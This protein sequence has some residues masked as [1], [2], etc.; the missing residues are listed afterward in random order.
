MRKN[1]AIIF[2][3][4]MFYNSNCYDDNC[5]TLDISSSD[6]CL[7]CKNGLY[8]TYD[9][10]YCEEC[11]LQQGK[12]LYSNYKDSSDE[13]MQNCYT[14]VDNCEEYARYDDFCELC[15]DGFKRDE[16]GQCVQCPANEVGMYNVCFKKIDHCQIYYLFIEGEK[17]VFCEEN[18]EFN[19][20]QGQCIKCPEGEVSEEGD[21]CMKECPLGTFFSYGECIDEIPNCD[22]YA[23]SESGKCS[24]CYDDY[25]LKEDGTCSSCPEG[26]TGTGLKCYDIM[27]FCAHQTD[28]ICQSCSNDEEVLNEER[29]QCIKKE[30]I[31]NCNVQIN[32]KCSI[33][34]EGYKSSKDQKSCE[35][36]EPGKDE[37]IPT[38]LNIENCASYNTIINKYKKPMVDCVSC[39]SNEYYLTTSLHQCNDCEKG[40]YKLNGQCIDEIK[41][42]VQYKSETI[43]EKCRYGYQ[44]KNG[45]CSPCVTPFEG[46]DG[47]ICHLT[48]FRCNEANIDDYG[49]C[50]ECD[51]GYILNSKKLCVKEG[52]EHEND[53]KNNSFGLN[54]NFIFLI[55]Y[56]LLI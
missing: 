35:I 14:K 48:H 30:K 45:R 43:C 2:I 39:I 24:K 40:K 12:I 50:Y 8:L 7:E 23:Q 31:Q 46:S 53:S 52:L 19:E 18:Y 11:D 16:N 6:L 3:L 42:C 28:D 4:F 25:E 1:I 32:D 38:C 5:Q 49:N 55:L 13:E 20:E 9:Q 33:C 41:N 22:I 54:I 29:N 34:K 26:K 56:G 47:K 51:M 36:C 27:H 37:D 10:R 44:V 17:C 21:I 15:K